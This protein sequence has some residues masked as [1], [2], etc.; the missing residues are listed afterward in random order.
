MSNRNLFSAYDD[1]FLERLRQQ[2]LKAPSVFNF[3][4]PDFSP[5]GVFRDDGLVAPVAQLMDTESVI[6]I[7][8]VHEEYVQRHHDDAGN[9]FATSLET[10]LLNT[11]DWQSLVSDDLSSFDDLIERL[12]VVFLAG[13]MTDEMRDVLRSVHSSSNP[14]SNYLVQHK[15]QIVIDLL[16]IIMVSPQ[17]MVQK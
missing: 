9:T 15:W 3:Y 16:N 12:N 10:F 17:F 7:A 14:N 2:P 6:G 4:Q 1:G 11:Q 5:P 13:A 8:T